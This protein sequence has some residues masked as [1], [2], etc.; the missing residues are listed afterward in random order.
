MIRVNGD[1]IPHI[2]DETVEQLFVRR[3]FD[4]Q[5]QGF[6]VAINGEVVRRSQWP[7]V[8]LQ[9]SDVVDII[10]AVQGG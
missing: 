9:N 3:G 10:G 1:N 6:A 4:P 7:S 5:Q 2:A 8:R